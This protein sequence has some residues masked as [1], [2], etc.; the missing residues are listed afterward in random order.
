MQYN[1]VRQWSPVANLVL[2][3]G[4][5]GLE[6]VTNFERAEKGGVKIHTFLKLSQVYD[7]YYLEEVLAVMKEDKPSV[8]HFSQAVARAARKQ[9]YTWHIMHP[10]LPVHPDRSMST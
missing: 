2:Y 4:A 10:E 5:R 3:W 7:P 8:G 6:A 9:W 1:T